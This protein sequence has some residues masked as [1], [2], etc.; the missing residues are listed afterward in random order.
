MENGVLRTV[1]IL[2]S[3]DSEHKKFNDIHEIVSSIFIS[4]GATKQMEEDHF[5]NADCGVLLGLFPSTQPESALL[6]P[7]GSV[8]LIGNSVLSRF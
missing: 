4:K 2:V 3:I 1:F 7:P 8:A 6:L 5:L